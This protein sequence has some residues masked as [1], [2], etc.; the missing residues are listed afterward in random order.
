MRLLVHEIAKREVSIRVVESPAD[1]DVFIQWVYD[2]L[3][4]PTAFD[5]ETTGLDVWSDGF[6]DPSGAVR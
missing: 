5:L 6:R 1:V 3:N 2:R 4:A